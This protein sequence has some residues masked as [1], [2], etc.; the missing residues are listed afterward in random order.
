LSGLFLSVSIV[1]L[2]GRNGLAPQSGTAVAGVR[3]VVT[4]VRGELEWARVSMLAGRNQSGWRVAR[5]VE[6]DRLIRDPRDRFAP[7]G[8]RFP[9]STLSLLL[10]LA[11]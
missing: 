1:A 2:P 5:S 11:G 3:K 8:F 4:A 6:T 10:Q 9:H 7:D